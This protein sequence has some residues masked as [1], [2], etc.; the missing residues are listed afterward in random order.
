MALRKPKKQKGIMKERF[1]TYILKLFISCKSQNKT[2]PPPQKKKQKTR[3]HNKEKTRK[4]ETKQE[5]QNRRKRE[6]ERENEKMRKRN[7]ERERERQTKEK[8]RETLNSSLKKTKQTRHQKYPTQTNKNREGLVPSE[9][10]PKNKTTN[11][12]PNENT[13]SCKF[14]PTNRNGCK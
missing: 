6:R 5:R 9:E 12:T 3:Q 11:P 2:T 7:R 4:R 10:P 14:G 8:E 1:L 13:I